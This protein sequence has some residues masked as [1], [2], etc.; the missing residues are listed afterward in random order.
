MKIIKKPQRVF[1][2]LLIIL[3]SSNI[4]TYGQY[5]FS[6]TVK[7]SAFNEG[8]YD[9]WCYINNDYIG[10]T[11]ENGILNFEYSKPSLKLQLRRI[12]YQDTILNIVF[13]NQT[14]T[15][16]LK[17]VSLEGIDVLSKRADPS[18]TLKILLKKNSKY[19]SNEVDTSYYNFKINTFSNESYEAL[20]GD[21][22][23]ISKG[24]L[25]K[26][27]NQTFYIKYNYFA[28]SLSLKKKFYYEKY[29]YLSYIF[30]YRIFKKSKGIKI[31][32]R[33]NKDF[34]THS[35]QNILV[36][37]SSRKKNN[38]W[39]SDY[40]FNRKDSSL[41]R[42]ENMLEYQTPNDTL[43]KTYKVFRRIITTYNNQIPK[44]ISSCY[45][46]IIYKRDSEFYTEIIEIKM[47]DKIDL[48]GSLNLKMSRLSYSNLLNK[49]VVNDTN[50]LNNLIELNKTEILLD[51][52]LRRKGD[53]NP[54]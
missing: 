52:S 18:E 29:N 49:K 45:Y 10:S 17:P 28:D 12:G 4:T 32:L 15:I 36:I 34:S 5:Q 27:D 3:L 44:N 33:S 24:H 2:S 43:E 1:Y 14:S 41:F 31:H 35:D 20:F 42:I 11:N 39:Q 9:T 7:N 40:Y 30:N 38:N 19:F 53:S 21:L 26:E 54:R 8:I 46:K 23:T 25:Q 6:I 37:R 47:I 16:Y 51:E 13:N 50:Y 22:Y 48:S